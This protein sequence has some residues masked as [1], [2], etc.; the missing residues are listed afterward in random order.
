MMPVS[1]VVVSNSPNVERA[2]ASVLAQTRPAH[3]VLVV[4][5][6]AHRLAS[7]TY[8]ALARSGVRFVSGEQPRSAALRNAGVRAT[9]GEWVGLL[10]SDDRLAPSYLDEAARLVDTGAPLIT[11]RTLLSGDVN[12]GADRRLDLATAVRSPMLV[13][14]SSLFRRDAWDALGG[15][16][17]TLQGDEMYDFWLRLLERGPA[18]AAIDQPLYERG[19]SRR[20][21]VDTS[22]GSRPGRPPSDASLHQKHQRTFTGEL[23]GT[24][25]GRDAVAD[26]L[27]RGFA[28]MFAQREACQQELRQVDAELG[29]ITANLRSR[30]RDRV[31]WG[32]LNRSEPF[33]P[34][35]AGVSDESIETYYVRCFLRA[36]AADLQGALLEVRADADFAPPDGQPALLAERRAAGPA[37]HLTIVDYHCLGPVAS[38]SHDCVILRFA[39]P[40]RRD[41]QNILG[42]CA[43]ILRPDAI[44]LATFPLV[45]GMARDDSGAPASWLGTG[46]A[47][48]RL[49][50]E[51]FD[52][53]RIQIHTYGNVLANVAALYGLAAHAI[54]DAELATHDPYFPVLIAARAQVSQGLP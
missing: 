36:H 40:G 11:S 10:D 14:P 26:Q 50:E 23:V 31:E 2:V 33:A 12:V 15:F 48:R 38:A 22:G 8:Q 1:L 6:D 41:V 4:E 27:R 25:C 35:A 32:D 34:A 52:A 28:A 43:R 19:A 37:R 21:S 49:L 47:A 54:S 16:D 24:I 44:L 45:G 46:A 13:H 39:P 20:S 17:E 18:G 42:E 9:R 3:E 5:S 53:D 29:A 30:G 51:R 7:G